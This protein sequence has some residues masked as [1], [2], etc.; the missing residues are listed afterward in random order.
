VLQK[1]KA[2]Y[3]GLFSVSTPLVLL[4]IY[5][6]VQKKQMPVFLSYCDFKLI[7]CVLIPI[8]DEVKM[9][10]YTTKEEDFEDSSFELYIRYNLLQFLNQNED[11]TFQKYAYK[12]ESPFRVL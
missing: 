11:F 9:N 4:D 5:Q 3:P 2:S 8:R 10:W 12:Q 6:T 1:K 7:M